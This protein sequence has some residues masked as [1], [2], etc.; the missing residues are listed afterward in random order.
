LRTGLDHGVLNSFARGSIDTNISLNEQV[1]IALLFDHS[2]AAIQEQGTPAQ[3]VVGAYWD[4]E[5]SS[6]EQRLEQSSTTIR[7]RLK[8]PR[9]AAIAGIL[10]SVLLTTTLLLLRIS[11]RPTPDEPQ[12]WSATSADSVVL[13]LNL[14]PFA[15]I[16]LSTGWAWHFLCGTLF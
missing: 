1:F 9:A 13:A 4:V 15:G 12:I 5:A 14:V 3:K 7:E 16:A 8:T 6:M 2:T 11:V 10:F